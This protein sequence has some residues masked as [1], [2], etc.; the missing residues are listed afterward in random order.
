[1][2][3]E[4]NELLTRVEGDAP[5]GRMMQD[6]F[7]VPAVRAAKLELGGRPTRL[8][9]FG[10]HFVGFRG[11]DG[12]VGILDEACPHRG[13]SLTL[14]R[15]EDCALRCIFHGWKID[16]DG[17]VLELP[18]EPADQQEFWTSRVRARAYPVREAG[19]I[20]WAYLG[21]LPEPPVFP[22]F[23]FTHLGGD[24]VVPASSIIHC[25]WAQALDVA[26]D[27][28]HLAILHKSY[29]DSMA[30]VISL[31][32]DAV[33]VYETYDRPY[34]LE[35][36]AVRTLPDGN[37]YLRV[38]NFVMPWYGIPCGNMPGDPY[39]NVL[40]SVPIDDTHTQQWFVRYNRS[41]GGMRWPM[42]T[43]QTENASAYY[44]EVESSYDIDDFVPVEDS[45]E[46]YWGQDYAA[47]IAGHFTGFTKNHLVEDIAVQVSMGPIVDRSRENLTASDR[48][49]AMVRRTL[50]NSV[51]AF[52]DGRDPVGV[53]PSIA[54]R[55]INSATGVFPDDDGWRDAV[56]RQTDSEMVS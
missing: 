42:S 2:R 35:A 44:G 16:A 18:G 47:M 32:A 4:D 46:N 23:D 26:L 33:P 48:G 6:H 43:A 45:P 22:D 40:M 56:A 5:M 15:N 27:S 11:V 31:A 51:R 55:E 25:N 24:S 20:I 30:G 41:G 13:V 3:A 36:A 38:S 34:G 8:R 53:D 19:G 54:F 21:S 49:V 39:R 14:A 12:R 7:W 28:A 37:R 50:L 17:K 29:I 9:L 1:M 10:R 52:V